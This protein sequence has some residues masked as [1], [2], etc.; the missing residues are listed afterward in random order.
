[1]SWRSQQ[2][3]SK[4]TSYLDCMIK[5]RIACKARNNCLQPDPAFFVDKNKLEALSEDATRNETGQ[6]SRLG[7][8]IEKPSNF[9]EKELA[10]APRFPI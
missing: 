1:M 3:Q 9:R 4:P 10:P 7:Q 8:H 2:L 5:Y 6:L